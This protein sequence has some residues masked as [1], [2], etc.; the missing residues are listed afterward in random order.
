MAGI[1]LVI[2]IVQMMV[3]PIWLRTIPVR[4][5]GV[6]LAVADLLEIAADGAHQSASCRVN[7][8]GL[9]CLVESELPLTSPVCVRA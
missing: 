8:G 5:R 4:A 1:V 9:R 3:S 6:A 2:W 7:G